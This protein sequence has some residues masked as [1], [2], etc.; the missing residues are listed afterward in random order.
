MKIGQDFLEIQYKGEILSVRIH[1]FIRVFTT[2]SGMRAMNAVRRQT[3]STNWICTTRKNIPA[4]ETNYITSLGVTNYI[5][6]SL[7]ETNNI[8][9]S[10]GETNCITVSLGDITILKQVLVK[11]TILQFLVKLIIL[12]QVLKKLTLFL[13]KAIPNQQFLSM[14]PSHQ[15]YS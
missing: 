7:G 6:A 14:L 3:R 5:P 2:E 10:L 11:L 1:F 12:Q 4:S 15:I 9:A 8:P 13:S